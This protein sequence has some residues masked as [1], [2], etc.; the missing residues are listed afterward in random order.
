M[1]K[2]DI[3]VQGIN[4]EIDSKFNL[5]NTI[6]KNE[7]TDDS[8]YSL[9]KDHESLLNGMNDKVFYYILRRLI[10]IGKF[11]KSKGIFDSTVILEN[12]EIKNIILRE[13]NISNEKIDEIVNTLISLI[14][15]IS[16]NN[17]SGKLDKPKSHKGAMHKYALENNLRCYICGSE[18]D[19]YDKEAKN[20]R[21]FEH[22]IPCSLGGNKTNKNIFIACAE[23]N[24]AK[25]NYVSW[26]ETGFSVKHNVFYNIETENKDEILQIIDSM[27]DENFEKE[28]LI[29]E[30]MERK[31]NKDMIFIV[32]NMCEYKCSICG[33]DNDISD[34]T[35]IIKKEQNDYCHPL[36]L[37]TICDKCLAQ[38]DSNWVATNNYITR[39]RISNVGN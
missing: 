11:V 30:K 14:G 8:V 29:E 27:E 23:C 6:I 37:M 4:H 9:I 25:S 16:S 22:V 7:I 10:Y 39:V 32:S 24:H 26:V 13:F 15:E 35:Y 19:Y 21:E 28:L 31:I 12:D 36:N 2:L 38:I 5:L 20:Y 34:K 17:V 3:N 33:V 18:V 1:K